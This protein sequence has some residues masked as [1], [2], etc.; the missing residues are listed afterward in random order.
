MNSPIRC[1]RA[2]RRGRAWPCLRWFGFILFLLA[3]GCGQKPERSDGVRLVLSTV[4][5]HPGTTFELRFDQ[6]V[7]RISQVGTPSPTSPLLIKPA[8]PGHF[9]Y[10]SS[11]S[12]VF[13]PDEPFTL[14][15]EYELSLQ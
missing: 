8:L 4:E 11:R 1:H 14:N 13:T 2:A 10:T 5:L 6:P 15:T 12:G 9:V 3:A 7:A